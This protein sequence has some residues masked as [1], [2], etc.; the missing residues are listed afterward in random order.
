M[1][2]SLYR[3]AKEVKEWNSSDLIDRVC[4]EPLTAWFGDGDMWALHRNNSIRLWD[5]L[6]TAELL[7]YNGE[8]TYYVP[9]SW[10]EGRRLHRY[11]R[12]LKNHRKTQKLL[13]KYK[14]EK[15]I[16]A[17]ILATL[18]GYLEENGG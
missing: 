6:F 15:K 7:I 17:K 2:D 5:N 3:E 10:A 4:S 8:S 13:E 12:S 1:S 11:V 18:T 16:E 14:E 9:R